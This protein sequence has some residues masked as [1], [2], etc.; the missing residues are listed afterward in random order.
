MHGSDVAI[1]IR[2]DA[3]DFDLETDFH[4]DGS[5]STFDGVRYVSPRIIRGRKIA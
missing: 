1:R 4:I 3:S 2:E 5:E